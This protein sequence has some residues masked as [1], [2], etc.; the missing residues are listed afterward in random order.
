MATP[1]SACFR[2]WG[3]VDAVARHGD[4][5]PLRLQRLHDPDL[6]FRVD[7]RVHRRMRQPRLQFFQCEPI[8]F[9]AGQHGVVFARN[10]Q[11]QG[12]GLRRAA[13]RR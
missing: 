1:I 13:D 9:P 6:L 8:E 3:V 10:A 2:A 11:A 4:E 5:F 7:A 12:D